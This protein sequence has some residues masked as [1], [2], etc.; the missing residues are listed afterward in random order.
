MNHRRFVFTLIGLAVA[1]L[2]SQLSA[3]EFQLQEFEGQFM[4]VLHDGTIVGRYMIAL[5]LSDGD[6]R[7]E[8][9]KPFLHI[10]DPQ[11]QQPITKGA[12]GQFT[13]HRGIFR[14]WSKLTLD[15]KSY[16]TWHM[17]GNVQEHV[18]FTDTS[19]DSSGAAFTS[20]IQFRLDDGTPLLRERRTM[21]FLPPPQPAYAMLDVTSVVQATE[22]DLVL[23]GDPEHAGLQFRPANE[24]VGSQTQY[25]YPVEN[26]NPH[27]DLDYPWVAESFVIG[28]KR[29]AVVYL[30]HP[31]NT[32][33]ARTSAYRSYGRFGMWFPTQV[34]QGQENVTR[35]RF[36]ILEGDLP[37]TE[38]IR[39]QYRAFTGQDCGATSDRKSAE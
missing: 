15:G 6:T 29:Y 24:V 33:G 34:P 26:A 21:H 5:D 28:D 36:L 30:N 3:A 7:H 20:V 19:V 11:G 27:K 10:F 35:V 4:D 39:E 2:G 18:Q 13:H 37:S 32:D 12:G 23:N 9:Y 14:G 8:T 17:K 25:A 31:Q 16:D 1:G 38:F 22:G